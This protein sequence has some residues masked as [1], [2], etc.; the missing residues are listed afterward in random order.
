MVCLVRHHKTEIR[1]DWREAVRSR[2]RLHTGH[3][4]LSIVTSA[5]ALHHADIQ[6]GVDRD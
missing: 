2:K 3:D 6:T 1:N 5:L 4:D